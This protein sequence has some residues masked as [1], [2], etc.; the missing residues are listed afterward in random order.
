[1][2]LANSRWRDQQ[3]YFLTHSPRRRV[4]KPLNI[5]NTVRLAIDLYLVA[6]DPIEIVAS[7]I[8]PNGSNSTDGHVVP[9]DGR[10]P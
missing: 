4:G 6:D 2:T 5:L 1:M 7:P 10:E 8:Q 3:A 9:S